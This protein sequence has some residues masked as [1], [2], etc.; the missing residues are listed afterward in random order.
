[1][2]FKAAVVI[3]IVLADIESK[4]L[5]VDLY[6]GYGW[7]HLRFI[8]MLPIYQVRNANSSVQ[9]QEC[10]AHVPIREVEIEMNSDI[11]DVYDSTTKDY[12]SEH[13]LGGGV[14]FM[15]FGISASFSK[16]YRELKERQGREQTVIIRNEIL[17]NT[18][19]VFLLR[20]CPLD[21]HL[22]AEIINIANNIRDDEPIM[23]RYAAQTFVLRYGTHYTSRFRIGGR[24]VEENFMKTQ[25]LYSSSTVTKSMQAGAKAS[26]IGKF[27]L[28][29]S[30][31]T[32]NSDT[33]NNI[34]QYQQK[35]SERKIT[36]HGGQPY[37]IGMPLKD[38]Q[39]SIDDNPVVLQRMVE[40][41]TMAIDPKQ[42]SEVEQYYVYKALEEINRAVDTY[43][44][45]NLMPGCLD[46]KSPSFNWLANNDNGKCDTPIYALQFGGFYQ[47]CTVHWSSGD[48]TN[49]PGG[50]CGVLR[51]FHTQAESCPS[52]FITTLL[53]TLNR[54]Q[55]VERS[56]SYKCGFLW[57]STCY[58]TIYVGT[59][60][61]TTRLYGCTRNSTGYTQYTFGG[62]FTSTKTNM[63]TNS[64]N[65]PSLYVSQRVTNDIDVC[66]TDKIVYS[67]NIP[68]FGGL[69]SC[70][71]KPWNKKDDD[72]CPIGY[73]AIP[74]GIIENSCI[75]H[76]CLQMR[77]QDQ[78]LPPISLPPYF[79]L[80]DHIN[81]TIP[82]RNDT[83][84]TDGETGIASSRSTLQSRRIYLE[85]ESTS[86]QHHVS[87]I[88]FSM[89]MIVWVTFGLFH[90]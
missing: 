42:I 3:L 62:S 88:G 14:G 43:V 35:V 24:I 21:S 4:S 18:A 52:G 72:M 76:A 86:I 46:R 50:L 81:I 55:R 68:K 25:D 19:D 29:A 12:S 65:C 17:H 87:P 27:S 36:A 51:N 15:G 49:A 41:I 34:N 83:N 90:P 80:I 79:N 85:L 45:M 53:H 58:R 8:D 61:I 39:A 74:M 73:N 22:K 26:F 48:S 28:S 75:L 5:F 38:W 89:M 56:D 10:I 54:I 63:V 13:I 31:G 60:T 44:R 2:L 23:A 70:Q 6:P 40:N 9:M 82:A 57:L 69:F 33:N 78:Q 47:N 32:S 1:M 59:A 7:D 20:S 16:Q 11:I 30:Y 84:I 71:T 66:V 77:T 37:L 64:R 67:N